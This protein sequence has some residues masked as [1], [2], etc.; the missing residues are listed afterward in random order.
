MPQDNP[1]HASRHVFFMRQAIALAK[2]GLGL[3]SP[4]PAVGAVV[5]RSGAVI[6]KGFHRKAGLPH[7]ERA[8]IERIKKINKDSTLYVTLEPCCHYGRTPPCT[9]LIIGSG[10]KRVVIG[11]VDP[12]PKVRGKGIRALMGAGVEVTTGVLKEECGALNEQYEKHITTGLPF[13]TLKL[14]T[15]LDGK[16]ATKTGE[17]RWIT[18]IEA[19]RFAHRLRSVHDAV[20]VG[21]NTVMKDDPE[22]TVRHLRGR[23][24]KRI[25]LDSTLRTPLEA[26]VFNNIHKDGG[27]ELIIFTTSRAKAG[28]VNRVR[29]KGAT[30]IIA[31]AGENG[32][33]LSHV[34]KELGRL[35]VTG[36]LVEG[37]AT[38]AAAFLKQGL[39]DRFML[40]V[41]PMIIG[42]DGVSAIGALGID[43]L[44]QALRLKDLSIKRLGADILFNG[45]F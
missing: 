34:L 13:V 17:S 4:N 28:D 41:S 30:V 16:I 22:L 2:K 20:M 37:G 15:T 9:D 5:V 3:T 1:P 11:A 36:V 7:A 33:S 29:E 24:P 32:L 6:S 44:K 43:R 31:P 10:I 8:A 39:V 42:G 21:C 38:L 25:V 35:G 19:R 26:R 14:A 23:N 45:N 12:N 27:D 18:G 40:C